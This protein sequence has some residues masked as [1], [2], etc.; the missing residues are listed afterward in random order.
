M[1]AQLF[2]NRA[3]KALKASGTVCLSY[4]IIVPDP[5]YLVKKIPLWKLT[6]TSWNAKEFKTQTAILTDDMISVCFV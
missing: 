6:I 4:L 3:E 1:F 2:V 5:S